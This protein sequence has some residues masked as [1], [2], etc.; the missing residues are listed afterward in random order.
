M[1]KTDTMTQCI[2]SDNVDSPMKHRVATITLQNT[3]YS[4]YQIKYFDSVTLYL[5]QRRNAEFFQW[6]TI[7]YHRFS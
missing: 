5:G 7:P 4:K 2:S 6:K 1:R 3:T